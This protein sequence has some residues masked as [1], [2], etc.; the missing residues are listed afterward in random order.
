M[1]IAD[2]L[3]ASADFTPAATP[4]NRWLEDRVVHIAWSGRSGMKYLLLP[5]LEPRLC[6]CSF[7]SL[8]IILTN[9]PNCIVFVKLVKQSENVEVCE[10]AGCQSAFSFILHLFGDV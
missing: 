10:Y 8:V 3:H 7:C 5:G 1:E 2:Q 9:F 4:S 6:S